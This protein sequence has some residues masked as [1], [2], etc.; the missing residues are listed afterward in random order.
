MLRS[1]SL[2]AP[3]GQRLPPW[4]CT[5]KR[6][7]GPDGHR[8]VIRGSYFALLTVGCGVL[9]FGL[10]VWTGVAIGWTQAR[11]MWVGFAVLGAV[12]VL[13][14]L[15]RCFIAR[16]FRIS[17]GGKTITLPVRFGD[18]EVEEISADRV[19]I[20]VDRL[21]LMQHSRS[22]EP[23]EWFGVTLSVREDLRAIVAIERTREAAEELR[24]QILELSA[25]R[26]EPNQSVYF[27]L[28][29]GWR[30]WY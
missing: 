24:S 11:E 2:S 4:R 14:G 18:R 17:N 21:S 22:W 16:G 26:R 9:C 28:A 23:R 1:E 29:I 7:V 15:P 27:G 6:D 5:L 13:I 10:M 20:A 25:S 8:F 30:A 12:L 3:A 19:S